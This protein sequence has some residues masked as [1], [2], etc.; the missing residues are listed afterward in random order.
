MC[1][2]GNVFVLQEEYNDTA[3][4]LSFAGT[5]SKTS[6][7]LEQIKLKIVTCVKYVYHAICDLILNRWFCW[8]HKT[9]VDRP[10]ICIRHCKQKMRIY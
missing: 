2:T 8:K 9:P 5:S 4:S 7:L 10:V 3:A 1:F 6:N